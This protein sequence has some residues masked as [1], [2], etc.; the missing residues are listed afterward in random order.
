MQRNRRF[1]MVIRAWPVSGAVRLALVMHLA[2]PFL[3]GQ[4]R[5]GEIAGENQTEDP[6]AIPAAIP[7]AEPAPAGESRQP[8]P[9]L[10]VSVREVDSL[11]REQL[12]ELRHGGLAVDFVMPGSPAERAGVRQHDILHRVD[13]QLLFTARQLALLIQSMEIGQESRLAVY[14]A[15]ESQE[16]AVALGSH[17]PGVVRAARPPRYEGEVPPGLFSEFP[18]LE[19]LLRRQPRGAMPGFR[20]SVIYL[21]DFALSAQDEDGTVE[22]SIR[23]GKE[24]VRI[25]DAEGS[26][27]FEG[28][29]EDISEG[30]GPGEPWPGKIS[31][32]TKR[33]RSSGLPWP[34]E[35]APVEEAGGKR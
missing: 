11:V 10:G 16:V 15:G 23:E 2:G 20:S 8:V 30:K 33:Y 14:R 6:A 22:I 28:T 25:R 4:D 26:L 13:D 27:V 24:A 35:V 7:A 32:L 19:E 9:W 3:W 12:P 31:A 34:S 17:T 18:Q 21:G 29:L 1:L 5:E